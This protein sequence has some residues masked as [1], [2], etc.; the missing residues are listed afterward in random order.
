M[1][2]RRDLF[3]DYLNNYHSKY[4][5]INEETKRIY[6]ERGKEAAKKFREQ[7]MAKIA[8]NNFHDNEEDGGGPIKR[9]GSKDDDKEIKDIYTPEDIRFVA[10]NN[11]VLKNVVQ[12]KHA[13]IANTGKILADIKAFEKAVHEKQD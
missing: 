10:H 11:A 9:K 1:A 13:V 7:E 5:T 3:L 12:F 2:E 6:T 4:I 8:E